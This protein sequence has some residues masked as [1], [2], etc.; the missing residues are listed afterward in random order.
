[1]KINVTCT[2]IF[3]LNVPG[4]ETVGEVINPLRDGQ[5]ELGNDFTNVTL[6]SG[7]GREDV[8]GAN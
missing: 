6:E 5:L 1:M 7:I 4:V 3:H 8:E 2:V